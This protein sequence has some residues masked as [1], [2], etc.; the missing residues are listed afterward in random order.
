MPS[1]WITESVMLMLF[2]LFQANLVCVVPSAHVGQ[3]DGIAVLQTFY[4][5]NAVDGRAAHL[6]RNANCRL[7]IRSQLE[8]R[9]GAVLITRRRSTDIEHIRQPVEV[10]RSI[11]AQVRSGALRQSAS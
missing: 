11:H 3:D 7:S 1:I 6:H 9:D 4:N 5:L 8:E 2:S 10:D